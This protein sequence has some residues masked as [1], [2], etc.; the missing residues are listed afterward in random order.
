MQ[1]EMSYRGL[2]L[3]ALAAFRADGSL[4]TWPAQEHERERCREQPKASD[5][6]LQQV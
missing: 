1:K 4:Q 5:W 6:V 2:I 3:S